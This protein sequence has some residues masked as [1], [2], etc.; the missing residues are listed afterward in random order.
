[1]EEVLDVL[2]S[3]GEVTGSQGV[4]VRRQSASLLAAMTREDGSILALDDGLELV[5]RLAAVRESR[6]DALVTL[7]NVTAWAHGEGQKTMD[8]V[9]TR[10]ATAG[11]LKA[12]AKAAVDQEFLD[13]ALRL[14]QNASTVDDVCWREIKSVFEGLVK[15]FSRNPSY[16]RLG[17]LLQNVTATSS[18]ARQVLLQRSTGIFGVLLP[19][20]QANEVDRRRGV[21]A[22]L[23]HC[24]MTKEEHFYLFDQLG[25]GKRIVEALAHPDD[26]D[27]M[28]SSDRDALE[29]FLGGRLPVRPRE[30]DPDVA[31]F[32]LDT[33]YCFAGTRRIRR[34]L[35]QSAVYFVVRDIDIA[36]SRDDPT[37]GHDP[38]STGSSSPGILVTTDDDDDDDG[39]SLV[40]RVS[41]VCA[42]LADMLMR[43][44]APECIDN[45]APVVSPERTSEKPQKS[46]GFDG[47]KGGFL[48]NASLSKEKKQDPLLRQS[49]T[50]IISDDDLAE[51]V[52]AFDLP[53]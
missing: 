17:R 7:V 29:Q 48:K 3:H 49:R 12:A 50:P 10:I 9:V 8:A 35:K 27:R 51:K 13:P 28:E 20:L 31:A 24:A 34:Q 45:F 37:G 6:H 15:R 47:L 46:G 21:A 38:S 43:D 39:S 5:C 40:S 26:V 53:D 23:K 44:E 4:E 52:G 42:D 41:R 16:A 30:S 25:A 22:A 1:M 11:G 32:L 33:L 2:R 36:F 18:E 14:L 19:H